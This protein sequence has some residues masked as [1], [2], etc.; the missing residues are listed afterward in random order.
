VAK[1]LNDRPRKTLNYETPA[2]RY[3]QSVASIS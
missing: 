3:R 1:K 2:Q